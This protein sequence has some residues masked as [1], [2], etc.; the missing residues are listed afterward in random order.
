MMEVEVESVK[1]EGEI[2]ED[3]GKVDKE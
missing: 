2:E 1:V 3:G